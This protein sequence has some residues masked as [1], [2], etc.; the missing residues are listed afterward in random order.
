MLTDFLGE[1]FALSDSLLIADGGPDRHISRSELEVHLER[2]VD[3][4]VTGPGV[5]RLLLLP[6]DHTRLFS[7]AGP[8][9]AWL[10]Q[11]LSDLITVDVM[12][13]LGTHQP[14]TAHECQLMFGDDV[15]PG[16]VL[17]HRWRHDITRL[18][19]ISAEEIE[20]LSGGQFSEP[21]PIEVNH[22]LLDAGYD[23]ILSVGQVVPHEVI[24]FANYT[25]N[26]CIGTG[27]RDT[28]HRSHFLG[29]VCGMEL[30]MGRVDTPV[31]RAVDDGFERFVRPRTNIRFVLTVIEETEAGPVQRGLYVGGDRDC[32]QAAAELSLQT[33]VSLVDEPFP[34]CVVYL[35]PREFHSM[36][37]GNKAIYRTRMAMADDGELFILAPGVKKFGEDDMVDALI[38]TYGYRGTEASLEAV[39]SDQRVKDNLSAAA[40]MIH[41]SSEGRFRITYCTANGLRGDEVESVGFGY[42]SYRETAEA[43]GIDKLSDGWHDGPD[44]KPFYFIRNPAL[45]LWST[46]SRFA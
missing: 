26:V 16:R 14:M 23:L 25:K 4:W 20:Q 9:T 38:R 21:L 34:R 40:H 27:G 29:A 41:G 31:R 30:I 43:F 28:I 19:E 10:Y 32:Y 42:R 36:W 39:A 13:A 3:H 5:Q 8:I 15:P 7:M 24:G 6:P 33:N 46:R 22:R 45:G 18:G 17:Q 1:E 44:G 37:L 35:D 12:P 2:I 11:R